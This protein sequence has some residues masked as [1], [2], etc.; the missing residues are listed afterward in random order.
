MKKFGLKVRLIFFFTLIAFLVF[1]AAAIVSWQETNETVDE[2]FDTY[3]MAL[4]RQ[5]AAA[6]WQNIT[7]ETQQKTDKIIDRIK[8][9]DD[10][11]EAIGFAVFDRFGNR[12]FHDNENGKSFVFNPTVGTFTDQRLDDEQWRLVWVSSTDGAYVIAVGQEVDFRRDIAW[13]MAEEFLLPWAL[14]IGIL[15]VSMV[16]IITIEFLPLGRLAKNIQ[17]RQAQDLSP[18]NDVGLPKEIKPLTGAMNQLLNKIQEMVARER[19]FIADSAHELRSPLT[20]LKV[21]LE[22]LELSQN[23]TQAKAAALKNLERGINRCARLVEQLLALSKA[24]SWVC[25]D[26]DECILWQNIVLSLMEEYEPVASQKGIKIHFSNDDTAP[27]EKGDMVLASLVVRNLLDNAL[28][29]SPKG[30]QIL[31]ILK[32]K[33]LSVINSDCAVPQKHLPYLGQRFYRPAGQKQMGSGL[34][35]SIVSRI[36]ALYGCTVRYE[37]TPGGFK[38]TLYRLK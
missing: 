9:A 28:K 34:G 11:D 35:L 8:G 14:G 24:Q 26:N 4:A 32:E 25:S 31:I 30:A 15:L 23:D 22:V 36:A 10:E 2:F 17:N 27:F 21:Q 20:A 19:G 7:I 33:T 38:V 3:Q 29:Y 37:N 13:D 5:L 6:D 1:S 16:L 12:V 18:L